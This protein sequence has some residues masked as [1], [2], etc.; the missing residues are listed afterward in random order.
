MLLRGPG[1][2]PW[3]RSVA[4]S[5]LARPACRPLPPLPTTCRRRGMAV[6]TQVPLP[7]AW[8]GRPAQAHRL[9]LHIPWHEPGWRGMCAKVLSDEPIQA[10]GVPISAENSATV[11][12]ATQEPTLTSGDKG[13]HQNTGAV[14]AAVGAKLGNIEKLVVERPEKAMAGL[15]NLL[16]DEGFV[17]SRDAA[18]RLLQATKKAGNWERAIIVY[19]R[20]N[21]TGVTGDLDCLNLALATCV[22]HGRWKEALDMAREVDKGLEYRAV[23]YGHLLK[24]CRQGQRWVKA[25]ALLEGMLNK[26][27]PVELWHYNSV[28]VTLTQSRKWSEAVGLYQRM[29]DT[30]GLVMDSFSFN[31]AIMAYNYGQVWEGT[32]GVRAKMTERKVEPTRMATYHFVNAAHCLDRPELIPDILHEFTQSGGVLDAPLCQMAIHSLTKARQWRD[33]LRI[34]DTMAEQMVQPTLAT[35]HTVLDACRLGKCW[36]RVPGI[37]D[38]IKRSNTHP[39]AYT[40]NISMEIFKVAQKDISYWSKQGRIPANQPPPP[41]PHWASAVQLLVE[42]QERGLAPN[43]ISFN[44]TIAACMYAG[45]WQVALDVLATMQESGVEADIVT[46]NS[47]I[48]ACKEARQLNVAL[49]LLRR[50]KTSGISPDYV[51]YQTLMQVCNSTGQ[52]AETVSL[53]KAALDDGVIADHSFHQPA[54]L[55]YSKLEPSD[56][57]STAI[58]SPVT[59]A[60]SPTPLELTID[61]VVVVGDGARKRLQEKV[62]VSPRQKEKD[63]AELE[64]LTVARY[65]SQMQR[66]L[67]K[68]QWNVVLHL[69]RLM[70][71]EG[72][73]NVRGLHIAMDA[74]L[75]AGQWLHALRLYHVTTTR[76]GMQA[77]MAVYT[78]AC[79]AV[80]E[81]RSVKALVRLLSDMQ[82]RHVVPS[83]EIFT[84][85]MQMVVHNG[86]PEMAESIYK[87]MESSGVKPDLKAAKV[88][89]NVYF[90]EQQHA[91]MV[92]HCER[93]REQGVPL[94]YNIYFKLMHSLGYA[95]SE[96]FSSPKALLDEL[97]A[98]HQKADR[99]LYK[100]AVTACV[101]IAS[102]RDAFD[103]LQRMREQSVPISNNTY[104]TAVL[105]CKAAGDCDGALSV[106]KFMVEDGVELPKWHT[107]Q[108]VLELCREQSNKTISKEVSSLWQTVCLMRD[109]QRARGVKAK[110]RRHEHGQRKE[111]A[112]AEDFK[113]LEGNR[114]KA[115]AQGRE[116]GGE[117]GKEL[118]RRKKRKPDTLPDVPDGVFLG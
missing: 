105:A 94:D 104:H 14:P 35:Y 72:V 26:G 86:R 59:P 31:T 112:H 110:T 99:L 55:A 106:L 37:L 82:E 70:V 61:G 88:L 28:L 38:A 6:T 48:G 87:T 73:S 29:L 10:V 5:L 27:I 118:P 16:A 100:A 101:P 117:R 83:L 52:W 45:Q 67:N 114:G 40:Y 76:I 25:T 84:M 81:G 116:L 46:Y 97:E 57:T 11:G 39:V 8:R 44:T 4:A 3:L 43:T 64:K 65:I 78:Q 96:Q 74:C 9:G 60:N 36:W 15:D 56:P 34:Y 108:S 54:T 18:L 85:A 109:A 50:M 77:D 23:T 89:M 17:L 13:A 71:E 91:D 63:P 75:R 58:T 24:A 68:N 41:Q 19:N 92:K 66:H 62:V 2:Q 103:I 33:A 90:S 22:E 7:P 47:A 1:R 102:Q 98:N 20:L 32:L 93:L 42:M 21:T 53:Y 95:V 12:E 115:Q 111:A 69:F 113:G 30:P 79:R 49:Q 80:M 51:T 107:I